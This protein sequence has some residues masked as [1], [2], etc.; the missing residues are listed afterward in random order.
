MRKRLLIS[1]IFAFGCATQLF[2]QTYPGYRTGNY[3]G[4]NGVFFNPANIADNRF[5]W[6]INLIAVNGFVGTDQGGLKFSDITKSFNAGDLKSN[7]LKGHTQLNSLDYVD[8]LG[9][10]FMLSVSP[11]TSIALTTRSRVFANVK[12]VNGDLANAII[13]PENSGITTPVSYTHLRAHET[14]S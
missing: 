2:S 12:D 8:I 7:L 11:K 10:S 1:T 13:D 6:D 5:K 14:D 3:T 9:P 4:V